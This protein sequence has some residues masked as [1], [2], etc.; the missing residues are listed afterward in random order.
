MKYVLPLLSA[1][2]ASPA[3]AHPAT[4]VHSH[5]DGTWVTVLLAAL[6]VGAAV[7]FFRIWR[8]T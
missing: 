1:V 8:R 4:H 6:A 2:V 3:V 7:A 5:N